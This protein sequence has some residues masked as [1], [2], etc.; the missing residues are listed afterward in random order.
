MS[1]RYPPMPEW[2]I[3]LTRFL[4]DVGTPYNRP[5]SVESER[6]Q[7]IRAELFGWSFLAV[8]VLVGVYTADKV[9]RNHNWL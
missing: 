2:T 9:A 5:S 4:L 1:L 8:A 7:R 6:K 3:K